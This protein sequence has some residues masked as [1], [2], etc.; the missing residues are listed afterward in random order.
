[1]FQMLNA[2]RNLIFRYRRDPTEG[3]LLVAIENALDRVREGST[4]DEAIASEAN[5]I[6]RKSLDKRA[7]KYSDYKLWRKRNCLIFTTVVDDENN[8]IGFFDI[9]PLTAEAGKKLVDGTL[10]ERSL[11][12]N[13]ILP[14]Q[15]TSSAT[16]I[17]IATVLLNPSQKTFTPIVA[18][19]V[20]LLKMKEFIERNYD[21][22]QT[23][24][25]SAYAQ[26]KAGEVFLRR[27][28][29]S[30]IVFDID[31]EQHLPLYV[32][33]PS[34]TGTAV[35]RFSQAEKHFAGRRKQESKLDLLNKRI[36][37]IEL[38]LR[39]C[40]DGALGGNSD[41]LPSHVATKINDRIQAVAK[42]D[43]SANLTRFQL[44]LAKLEFCDVR[45][46]QDTIL[47]KTIWP[48]FRD[49]FVNQETLSARFGQ[50][51][52]LRNAVRHSRTVDDI[53]EKDG[54]AS[55]MWFEKVLSKSRT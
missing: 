27:C 2:L 41:L 7:I 40:I 26:S 43:A 19:E 31:N 15:L 45:E 11:D 30:M 39:Q 44:M 48:F 4:Y 1:M 46:L 42:K 20:L 53:V 49:R 9:F 10:T 50:L 37:K 3:S 24:T 14:K 5:K 28:D 51:A 32:L 52:E 47:N 13:D 35:M 16:H 17:H 23:R 55:I 29:F 25:F 36:E 12:A 34:E 22:V 33:R 8:L 18:K 38:G 54:E 6:V 21:P